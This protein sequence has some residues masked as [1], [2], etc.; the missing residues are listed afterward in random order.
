MVYVTSLAVGLAVGILYGVIG[1]RSPAPPVAA[2][3]GLLGMLAGENGVAA[4]RKSMA[5]PARTGEVSEPAP[6]HDPRQS[7]R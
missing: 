2:I 7:P 3:L 6:T 5:G 4:I 1:L